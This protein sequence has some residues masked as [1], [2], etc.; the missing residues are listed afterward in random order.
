MSD[1]Q[2]DDERPS[3]VFDVAPPIVPPPVPTEQRPAAGVTIGPHQGASD[4][5]ATADPLI[6]AGDAQP[7]D[8]DSLYGPLSEPDPAN[9]EPPPIIVDKIVTDSSPLLAVAGGILGIGAL[10]AAWWATTRGGDPVFPDGQV[11]SPQ[12]TWDAF[13]VML[14]EDVFVDSILATVWHFGLAL[15]VGGVIG[16]LI[17]T[18]AG[19][20]RFG[21]ALLRPIFGLFRWLSPVLLVP[22]AILRWGAQDQA[23]WVPA[24]AATAAAVAWATTS[25]LNDARRR[26]SKNQAERLVA[27]F[28]SALPLTWALVY[29]GEM[30]ASTETI[31]GQV[32]ARRTRFGAAAASH[33]LY[34]YLVVALL[35]AL[36]VDGGLR[37]I[38]H[39]VRNN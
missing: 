14:D 28:R 9:V 18:A 7:L 1:A 2:D 33:E 29:A 6:T 26:L 15:G 12:A 5:G 31:G 10:V 24:A 38:Q 4:T 21:H 37:I 20:T 32:F 3:S 25:A 19:S 16:A 35:L 30:I 23:V 27:G 17:G 39:A 11:A 34:V 8:L 13:R 22:V 36:L